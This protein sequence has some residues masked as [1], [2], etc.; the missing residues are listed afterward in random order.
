MAYIE[1]D[2]FDQ[3]VHED[4]LN[5]LTKG[6]DD[7]ITNNINSTI[8]EMKGYL[9]GRYDVNTEFSKTGNARNK[10]LLRIG[11][12]LTTYYLYSIHNP[13]KITR[14]I[15]LN[16]EKAVQDLEKIQSGKITPDGLAPINEADPTASSGN[17]SPVQWGSDDQLI[18]SY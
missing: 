5:A 13:R 3:A 1:I 16:S 12:H 7:K 6:D 18:S 9:N 11:L 15:E 2:D 10:F 14:T 4:I 17:G 8:D